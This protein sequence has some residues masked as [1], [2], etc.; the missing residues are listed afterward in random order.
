MEF[1]CWGS[2]PGIEEY[3]GLVGFFTL[4]TN[5]RKTEVLMVSDKNS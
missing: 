3:I 2:S 1:F 5:N 4:K